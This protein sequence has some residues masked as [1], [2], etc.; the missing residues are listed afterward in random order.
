MFEHVPSQIKG[1]LSF[2]VNDH[3]K[4]FRNAVEKAGESAEIDIVYEKK[5]FIKKFII[6]DG[7]TFEIILQFNDV[8]SEWEN[9]DSYDEYDDEIE[10]EEDFEDFSSDF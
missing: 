6:H 8:E 5:Q 10:D 2:C 9:S 1:L 3:K 7:L 4:S